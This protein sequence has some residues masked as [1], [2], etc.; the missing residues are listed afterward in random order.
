MPTY[1]LQAIMTPVLYQSWRRLGNIFADKDQYG[2]EVVRIAKFQPP[3]PGPNAV[4][5]MPVIIILLVNF[6]HW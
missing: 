5:K 2:P 6:Q 3:L 1:R 4:R